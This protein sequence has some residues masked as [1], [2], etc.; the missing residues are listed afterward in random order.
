MSIPCYSALHDRREHVLWLAI[1]ADGRAYYQT[2][3]DERR[4]RQSCYMGLVAVGT[5]GSAP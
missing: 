5:T 2:I 1:L 3:I 4:H